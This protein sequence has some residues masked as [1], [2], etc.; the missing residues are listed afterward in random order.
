VYGDTVFS[1]EGAADSVRT[2]IGTLANEWSLRSRPALLSSLNDLVVATTL[3]DSAGWNILDCKEND[4]LAV[5]EWSSSMEPPPGALLLELPDLADPDQVP[6]LQVDTAE[7]ARDT[8]PHDAKV[9]DVY[10]LLA[11]MRDKAPGLNAGLG[12]SMDA[13]LKRKDIIV[14][15]NDSILEIFF[16]EPLVMEN[17][18]LPHI[19]G[20]SF[21]LRR[22]DAAV[23]RIRVSSIFRANRQLST[24]HPYCCHGYLVWGKK[25]NN[26]L[27]AAELVCTGRINEFVDTVIDRLQVYDPDDALYSIQDF[28]KVMRLISGTPDVGPQAHDTGADLHNGNAVG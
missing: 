9:V 26:A 14:A 1:G 11:V 5:E 13:L 8:S 19:L 17:I 25:F 24:I 20:F 4:V 2:R 6:N 16:E 15:I 18:E 12:D 3:A 23:L 27:K 7:A 21:D 10:R 22:P 28:K